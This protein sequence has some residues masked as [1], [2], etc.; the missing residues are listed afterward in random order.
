VKKIRRRLKKIMVLAGEVRNCDV[1]LKLLTRPELGASDALRSEF[2]VRRKAAERNLLASLRR[3]KER[4][5]SSRWRRGLGSRTATSPFCRGSVEDTAR[6]VLPQMV[7]ELFERGEEAAA[8][9]ASAKDLHKFRITSKRARY[10]LELFAPMYGPA[11]NNCLE[12]LKHIQNLLGAINDCETVR[13]MVL[14]HG[15]TET[16]AALKKRQRKKIEEFCQYW[17]TELSGRARTRWTQYLT[18]GAGR[19]RRGPAKSAVTKTVSV[20]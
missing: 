17:N 18:H 14:Q 6:Q 9:Q 12:Q 8:R 7:K 3:W 10:S 11:L 5:L 19:R 15:G 4:N 1:A 20:L 13:G 16:A 2:P